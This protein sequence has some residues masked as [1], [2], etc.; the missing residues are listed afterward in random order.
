MTRG[1]KQSNE[2]YHAVS[3]DTLIQRIVYHADRAALDEFAN[4]RRL[5]R[6]NDGP[7][8]LL[9]EFVGA[10]LLT[11][12][13]ARTFGLPTSVFER[14]YD[15]TIDK[16]SRLP[17]DVD[18][19]TKAL[20]SEDGEPL[21]P[22]G[23]DCRHYFK[24]M[25]DT[26][27]I[28]RQREPR[29]DPLS[30]EAAT[31]RIA[32]RCVARHCWWSFREACRQLKPGWSRYRW[33]RPDGSI[34]VWLPRRLPA[35]RRREWL[36]SHVEEVDPDRPEEQR[37]IQGMIDAYFGPAESVPFDEASHSGSARGRADSVLDLIIQGEVAARGLVDFVAKEKALRLH[38][39]RPTVRHLGPARLEAMI[40]CA[41][42]DP[43]TN[44]RTDRAIAESFGLSPATFSRFAGRRRESGD[45]RPLSDLGLNVARIVDR[46]PAFRE[47]AASLRIL[48]R[49]EAIVD[50]D[51]D[52]ESCDDR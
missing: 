44:H 1:I 43:E 35:S 36:E 6:H 20:A 10:V 49:I 47:L 25:A 42:D 12:P 28:R 11:G 51:H 52:G 39:Q 8:L 5:F 2:D 7:P 41:L 27:R 46:F 32:Q 23:T 21:K 37:R 26:I 4:H 30:L 50:P 24:V 33:D 38:E 15:L 16:F 31:A 34:L 17:A 40:R 14:A 9:V 13:T 29:P 18:P 48:D 19:D 22:G 45:D 3:T